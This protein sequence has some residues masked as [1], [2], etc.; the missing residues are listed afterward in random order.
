MR[1]AVISLILFI[2]AMCTVHATPQ[3]A[4]N[5][6]NYYW[7]L[8]GNDKLALA[9]ER[10]VGIRVRLFSLSWQQMN[11]QEN[12]ID[13]NYLE[14]KLK[15]LK[16]FRQAGYDVI[17]SLGMHD[18]P[19]WV[20]DNYYDT[21]YVSQY[22]ERYHD[23]G[24][25]SGDLNLVFNTSLRA[26]AKRYVK[27]VFT[28]FGTN[29]SAVR[30]GGG[31]YG[32]LTY[33]PHEFG[34]R[35]NLYWGFD[36]FAKAQSP[37]PGWKPGQASPNG[38]AGIFLNWYLDKLTAY[39]NWQVTMTRQFYPGPLMILYP[40]WG[41][42]KG[43]ID[44]AIATNLDGTSHAERNGEIQR[45][46]DFSRQINALTDPNIIIATT[47][48]DADP[49]QDAGTDARYWS[50]V[51]YLANLANRHSPV[52][53]LYGENTG[54]GQRDDMTLSASQMEKYGLMGMMWFRDEEMSSGGYANLQDYAQTIA[55]FNA[56]P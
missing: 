40:S 3:S 51:K 4:Q 2:G 1:I 42:R 30:L 8:M 12:I 39:Q 11:P 48:L 36:D 27:L 53:Q 47:W 52:Y 20:H 16:K 15:E 33:P 17:L 41:I 6:Q 49:S 5:C 28:L 22:S 43:D 14:R 29:F 37:V 46:F 10:A 54:Q 9:E 44:R 18:T 26:V 32:E 13:Q 25:D 24:N 56:C 45:G 31:R 50:P 55:T 38:E 7:G 35:R 34:G 21:Y 19:Q 23:N